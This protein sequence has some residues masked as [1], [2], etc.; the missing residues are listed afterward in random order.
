METDCS[1]LFGVLA[2]QAGLITAHQFA[3]A[4][5]VRSNGKLPSP[6]AD[7]L[8]DRGWT[9]A[10]DVAHI[11]Y[12]VERNLQKHGG[13]LAATLADVPDDVKRRLASMDD[14][15]LHKTLTTLAQRTEV[16]ADL[17]ETIELLP[18]CRQRYKITR[19]HAI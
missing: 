9:S 11:N 14:P 3:E 13:N 12:L 7:I 17:P 5:T 2:L 6:P 16:G 18:E 10:A 8:Q 15:E 4:C 19:L 1:L